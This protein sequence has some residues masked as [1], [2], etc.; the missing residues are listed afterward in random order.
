[1]MVEESNSK[2]CVFHQRFCGMASLT[3]SVKELER[4]LVRRP[5]VTSFIDCTICLNVGPIGKERNTLRRGN[6]D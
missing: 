5:T 1:M 6:P 3:E 2:S 4:K